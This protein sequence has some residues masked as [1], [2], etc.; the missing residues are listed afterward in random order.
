MPNMKSEI[1]CIECK[2]FDNIYIGQTVKDL[3]TDVNKHTKNIK[4]H[5]TDKSTKVMSENMDTELEKQNCLK[6]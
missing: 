3:D 2:D 6:L 4:S 1:Y 5:Q